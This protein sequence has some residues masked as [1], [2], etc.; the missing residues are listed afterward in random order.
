MNNSEREGDSGSN[1]NVVEVQNYRNHRMARRLNNTSVVVN[2]GTLETV[3][4]S[5]Q[6]TPFSLSVERVEEP[7]SPLDIEEPMSPGH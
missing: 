2:N 5:L 6:N 1:A 7:M 4:S 3:A